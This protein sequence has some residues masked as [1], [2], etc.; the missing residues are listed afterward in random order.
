MSK[1]LIYGCQRNGA[2]DI[3]KVEQCSMF[4]SQILGYSGTQF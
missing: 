2:G 1:R 3:C 4:K